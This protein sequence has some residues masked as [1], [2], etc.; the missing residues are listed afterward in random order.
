MFIID[1]DDTLFDTHAHKMLRLDEV[2]KI[3]VSEDD[4][5]KAY[6]QV[7]KTDDGFFINSNDSH[8]YALAQLGYDLDECGFALE[9]TTTSNLL[10]KLL[11][12]GAVDLIQFLKSFGDSL[13]LLSL[14]ESGYQEKKVKGAG[15]HDFFDRVFMVNDTKNNIIHE[16][17]EHVHDESIWFINDKVTETLEIKKLFPKIKIVLKQS[18][19][20]GEQEYINSN[21]PYYKTL[22][23]IK[24]YVRENYSA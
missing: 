15:I 14:G 6:K 20:I 21:F 12:R 2:K 10:E 4:Y 11:L 9:R 7:R 1:F 16:I 17:I 3:G 5:W 19:N 24:E 22:R 23:E 13:V 8:A 18:P